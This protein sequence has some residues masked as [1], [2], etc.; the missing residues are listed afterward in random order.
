MRISNSQRGSVLIVAAIVAAIVA[1]AL[2]SY[3]QL[4]RNSMKL[5]DRS[6]CFN[7]AMNL[8]DIGMEQALWNLNNS[9]WSNN[10]WHS[11]SG[12]SNQ[13]EATFPQP[14]QYYFLQQGVKGQVKVWAD[15]SGSIPHIVTRA[16]VTLGD[17]TIL[18]KEA[19][20]YAH[21]SSYF[22]NGLVAKNTITFSGNNAGSDSWNSDPD[23]NPST[24]AIPFSSSIARDHAEVGS[25]SVQV[26][27]VSVSNADV[28]GYV[29]VGGNTT[30][31]ISVGP[32][33]LVGPYGT[34]LGTIDTSHVTYDFTTSF[35]DAT[36]PDS[37]T[38]TQSY[39]IAAIAGD[40]TLPRAGDSASANGTYYY[41]AP[42]ISLSGS[43]IGLQIG[44]NQK[45]AIIVTNTTGTTV[46]VSGSHAGIII[47]A[48][49]S[50]AMYTSGDVSITGNGVLNGTYTADTNGNV[51]SGTPNQPINFALYGTRPTASPQTYQDIKI[52]GN[53]VLSGVVYAP[54]ASL[55]MKGGGNSG[56]VL[57]AAVANTVRI[58][59]NSIFHYDESLAN[60]N[61]SNLWK[62]TKWCE[63]ASAADRAAYASELNF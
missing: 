1:I 43:I 56:Q 9:N 37:S 27:S 59:G 53:G 47:P 54:N 52:A 42:S 10:D 57:G 49:S 60:A 48:G 14:N 23:N 4:A 41:Y 22:A 30:D 46:S 13:Y 51:T 2:T 35:P 50:L 44:S 25:T 39:M 45:V 62:L 18:T 34:Q 12:Y 32:R 21:G 61:S 3:L 5:A 15:L 8:V 19:E 55:E 11:R 7:A 6:F 24:P 33:G 26:D 28:Y 38:I 20:I 17:G 29:A 36:N 40:T 31:D 58:T 16:I 63:L